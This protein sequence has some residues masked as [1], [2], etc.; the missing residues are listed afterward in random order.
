M[1]HPDFL[2][3]EESSGPAALWVH[4][5]PGSGKSHLAARVIHDLNR[6][7][8]DTPLAYVYCSSTQ[9]ADK[10][11]LNNIFG[12]LL[13][14]LYVRLS[15][16]HD[17]KSLVTR[18]NSMGNESASRSEMKGWILEVIAK[19][20]SCF[21]VIDALD[22][23]SFFERNQFADLCNFV[24][25]LPRQSEPQASTKV[26]IF[27]RPNYNIIER[28]LSWFPQ[29]Q[30][31]NGANAN[32]IEV[33]ISEMFDDIEPD[34][35][36]DQISG[37]NDI[38]NMMLGHADGMFLWVQLKI[39]VFEQIGTVEGIME[40][41]ENSTE[42]LDDLYQQ[43][44]RK[45]LAQPAVVRDRALKALLWVVNA[46]TS[47]SKAELLEA[48]SVKPGSRGITNNSKHFRSLSI[49]TECAD[50]LVEMNGKYQLLHASLRD[51]VIG[52]QHTIPVYTDL[53]RNAHEILAET[54]L[55]YLTFEKLRCAFVQQSDDLVNLM[56]QHPLLEYASLYWGDH[57]SAAEG[58]RN[59]RLHLLL[60]TF[61]EAPLALDTSIKVLESKEFIRGIFQYPGQ[62]SALHVL[63][64]LNLWAIAEAYP[65][66]K[67]SI[68]EHDSLNYLPIDYAVIH[69][70]REM[71]EWLL[72][73]YATEEASFSTCLDC[74][75]VNLVAQAISMGWDDTVADLVEMR[76]EKNELPEPNPR[77]SA[78]YEAVDANSLAV[79]EMMLKKGINPNTRSDLG[80]TPL[81]LATQRKSVIATE[82]LLKA[83]AETNARGEAGL[84]ALHHAAEN[85]H[86]EIVSL[87]LSHGAHVD[88]N[89][90]DEELWDTPLCRA[91]W[92]D[93]IEAAE[94]LLDAGA[95]IH[96][97]GSDGFNPLLIS[98]RY[99]H[100]DM[101]KMLIRRGADIKSVPHH[102]GGNALHMAAREGHP[103]V[104][105]A[106]LE[107]C[108]DYAFVDQKNNL[109]H[110]PISTALNDR[111][112]PRVTRAL[113]EN[114]A[115]S[116]FQECVP[117]LPDNYFHELHRLYKLLV[118]EEGPKSTT[119][120][121]TLDT[122]ASRGL[123]HGIPHRKFANTSEGL[124]M[125][126][127]GEEANASPQGIGQMMLATLR[128]VQTSL[129]Q[130]DLED[131][132]VELL[133]ATM[134]KCD[135]VWIS[136]VNILRY[137]DS[138]ESDIMAE[139]EYRDV[140]ALFANIKNSLSHVTSESDYD[141]QL[142]VAEAAE[143]RNA[144]PRDQISRCSGGDEEDADHGP[145]AG[146][147]PADTESRAD[148]CEGF[149]TPGS[150]VVEFFDATR[151]KNIYHP[152]PS[153]ESG[154]T[155]NW[156][157]IGKHLIARSAVTMLEY[158]P[159]V[160]TESF[161]YIMDYLVY[162]SMTGF[163]YEAPID[164]NTWTG[165]ELTDTAG[166]GL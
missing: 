93:H 92:K 69:G 84:T 96:H 25:S 160:E 8:G 102:S 71:T 134:W 137:L 14:Q 81:I 166:T 5:K 63:S 75:Q 48:L 153:G 57:F 3:W 28:A 49:C 110:T 165:D 85:G 45:I 80:V 20:R 34:P 158:L 107:L 91:V 41:L 104:V 130:V 59:D 151:G 138:Y 143:P 145:T 53:Q 73:V 155:T 122:L 76:V 113:L 147:R 56:E 62:P 87:L 19:L 109:G 162:V 129:S 114:G 103:R 141:N 60:V 50:L 68:N 74:C 31:D 47:L 157:E 108:K 118:S 89:A 124:N 64:I 51:F 159:F 128:L 100:L 79:L 39:R 4:G 54:C 139:S 55:T 105:E 112:D 150:D 83:G 44:F 42:G 9:L 121:A 156:T 29:I 132:Y 72:G 37:L 24:S 36:D 15:P 65:R 90:D 126:S 136:S 35:L 140:E 33:Y 10:L 17:V 116:D 120:E 135:T 127:P 142:D 23:C 32:D 12:S 78:I 163:I 148:T 117:F 67:R 161:F 1:E 146:A 27:S 115:E 99:N 13:A 61:L 2:E 98:I 97:T 94:I 6:K 30:I 38:K 111:P 77:M 123:H 144:T 40:D 125:R 154:T 22:E 106:L 58:L 119:L 11:N 70:S 7:E 152:T 43:A 46:Y 82:M 18:A 16:E 88:V 149:Q 21:I 101:M 66:F 86:G 164:R 52:Q 95:S 131:D 133:A 26:I